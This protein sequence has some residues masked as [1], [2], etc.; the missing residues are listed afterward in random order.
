MATLWGQVLYLTVR[1][2][3]LLRTRVNRTCLTM[4]RAFAERVATE[5]AL[6]ERAPAG[7]AAAERASAE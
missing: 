2:S 4:R 7:R 1:V 3:A 6:A 5:R